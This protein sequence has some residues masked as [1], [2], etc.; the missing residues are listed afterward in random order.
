M[1]A[2]KTVLISIFIVFLSFCLTLSF[3]ISPCIS[4]FLLL[5][6]CHNSYNTY[7]RTRKE[8]QRAQELQF[9]NDA[10]RKYTN[11][12]ENSEKY[13]GNG[14]Y[15]KNLFNYNETEYMEI[16]EKDTEKEE[17]DKGKDRKSSKKKKSGKKVIRLYYVRRVY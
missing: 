1:S 13:N 17:E 5:K 4:L 15:A 6:S 10:N 2:I 3:F 7:K 8:L 9:E 16:P 11:L 12:F 14:R